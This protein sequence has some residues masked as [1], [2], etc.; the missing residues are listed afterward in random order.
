[1]QTAFTWFVELQH[2]NVEHAW[3]V[4]DG[5][6]M[7]LAKYISIANPGKVVH[8]TA[9][10]RIRATLKNGEI[11]SESPDLTKFYSNTTDQEQH[12]WKTIQ[13]LPGACRFCA[14]ES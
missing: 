10:A 3:H 12:C 7:D 1:M 8:I 9:K 11:T 2:A 6:V 4:S 14:E 13:C 5:R